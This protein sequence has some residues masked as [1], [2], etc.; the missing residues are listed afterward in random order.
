MPLQ[1]F[2]AAPFDFSARWSNP[3]LV[4]NLTIYT[5]CKFVFTVIAVGCPIVTAAGCEPM[6]TGL[7]AASTPLCRRARL[8]PCVPAA[9]R[10]CRRAC[11]PLC[12]PAC[13]RTCLPP[14]VP[15]YLLPLAPDAVAPVRRLAHPSSAR[16]VTVCPHVTC[17]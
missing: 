16:D 17:T 1:L 2:G 12:V 11:L 10:A 8:P 5:V 3:S 15:A 13:R 9:V 7:T 4:I 6:R 14:R